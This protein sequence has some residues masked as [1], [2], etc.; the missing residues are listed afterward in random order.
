MT[1][2]TNPPAPSLSHGK[3]AP[4]TSFFLHFPCELAVGRLFLSSFPISSF[5]LLR[6]GGGK[7]LSKADH[8]G[9]VAFGGKTADLVGFPQNYN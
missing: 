6:G 8:T 3:V 9:G 7:K 2:S 4:E 5:S 1:L